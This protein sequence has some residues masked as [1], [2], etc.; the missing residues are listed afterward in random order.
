MLATS[1]PIFDVRMDLLAD[2]LTTEVFDDNLDSLAWCLSDL[3]KDRNVQEYKLDLRKARAEGE[4]YHLIQ[5]NVHFNELQKAKQFPLF[6]LGRY[7]GGML[8][9]SRSVR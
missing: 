4:R 8:A 6:R 5:R 9:E 1:V 3:F 2:G 7:K